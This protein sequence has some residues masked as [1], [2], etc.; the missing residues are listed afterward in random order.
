[1]VTVVY[2]SAHVVVGNQESE[3][4]DVG[5]VLSFSTKWPTISGILQDFNKLECPS[6]NV[7]YL[8]L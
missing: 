3:Q 8:R 5:F 4:Y 2:C 1:M 6:L 7:S